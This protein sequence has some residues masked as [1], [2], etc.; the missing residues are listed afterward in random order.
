M[1]GR[2]RYPVIGT[3]VWRI[4]VEKELDFR[5]DGRAGHFE[6][7]NSTTSTS[8]MTSRTLSSAPERGACFAWL[9]NRLEKTYALSRADVS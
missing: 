1:H 5:N 3:D 8:F 2:I 6:D 9:A 4:A 7:K